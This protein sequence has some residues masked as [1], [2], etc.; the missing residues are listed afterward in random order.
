MNVVRKFA[1]SDRLESEW[2]ALGA[3]AVALQS[4]GVNSLSRRTGLDRH[5]IC[6]GVPAIE[7]QFE[8]VGLSVERCVSEQVQKCIL[9]RRFSGQDATRVEK[10]VVA[11]L[12]S[13]PPFLSSRRVMPVFR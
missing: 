7:Y 6:H 9:G 1:D 11:N 5:F 3:V 8:S 10:Y 13:P 4:V 2:D 12:F